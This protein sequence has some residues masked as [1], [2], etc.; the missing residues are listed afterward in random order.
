MTYDL[1]VEIKTA[2]FEGTH[3]SYNWQP[4]Y[5]AVRRVT[6]KT[7]EIY[8]DQLIEGRKAYQEGPHQYFK[9]R[10]DSVRGLKFELETM[11]GEHKDE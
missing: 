9:L 11:K 3:T 4:Y 5:V 1:R 10:I 6:A 2:H 7:V 8:C